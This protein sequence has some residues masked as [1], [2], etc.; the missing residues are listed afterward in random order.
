[1]TKTFIKPYSDNYQFRVIDLILSIQKDEFLI[2]IDLEK[3]PDLKTI[4]G[5]YQ[6]NNGN[7][8]IALA[9]ENVIGTIALL[10]IGNGQGAL[11]KM[12]VNKNY[13]GKEFRIGQKLL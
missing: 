3:Q 13:R 2:P 10:D 12:F 6:T 11:R 4:G 8:W 7:F 1:M 9:E 5:F